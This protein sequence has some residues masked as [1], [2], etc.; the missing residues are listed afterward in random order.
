VP[1][2][3]ELFSRGSLRDTLH[4]ASGRI[5]EDVA[6]IPEDHLLQADVEEL[7]R[8]LTER[9]AM[10]VPA[11]GEP[12]MDP[13]QEIEVDVSGDFTRFLR[14]PAG[15]RVAG[16]RV[17]V[18]IPFKGDGA[19]FLLCPASYTNVVPIADV[20]VAEILHVIEYPHDRQVDIKAST[21]RLIGEIAEYLAWSAADISQYNDDIERRARAAADNRRERIRR[22]REHLLSTGLPTGPPKGAG[23]TYIP[24]VLVRRPAPALPTAAGPA[25]VELEP[26]LAQEIFEHIL[27]AIRSIGADI[28]RSPGTYAAM[29][30]EDLRQVTLTALKPHYRGRAMAEAFN[31]GG[32]SD[33]LIRHDGRNLFIAEFKFWSGA[34]RFAE[35]ID[36]LFKHAAWRDTKLALVIFVREREL[37]SVVA[38]AREALTQHP[39]FRQL[40]DSVAETE[41][42]ASMTWPGDERRLADLS[43]LFVHIPRAARGRS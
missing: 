2:R 18:H 30:E 39:Q 29:A 23:A 43:V 38:K 42:R 21:E 24:D 12:W 10:S 13:A 34:K 14:D 6:A 8:A 41:L 20:G 19:V 4:S 15:A 37:T 7:A 40:V 5:E 9:R 35:T 26:V 22:H 28:E 17:V 32:S 1:E 27:G 33:L 11:L 25:P 31:F 3:E 36:Q 16:Y